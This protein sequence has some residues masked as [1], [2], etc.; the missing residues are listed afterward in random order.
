MCFDVL[1][2][3]TCRFYPED[4]N[5][6]VHGPK[7]RMSECL[8]KEELSNGLH[9]IL[10]VLNFTTTYTWLMYYF[11]RYVV[12]LLLHLVIKGGYTI[13]VDWSSVP[14]LVVPFNNY[15]THSFSLSVGVQLD[16][17][18]K[19]KKPKIFLLRKRKTTFIV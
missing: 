18:Q 4:V 9:K 6:S 3:L 10:Q 8:P 12:I 7:S 15:K 13:H 14:L 19:N 16:R 2:I 11:L 17:K 1:N 5:K